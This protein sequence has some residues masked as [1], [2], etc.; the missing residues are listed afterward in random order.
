MGKFNKQ[1]AEH[2]LNTMKL[3]HSFALKMA[4]IICWSVVSTV[5]ILSIFLGKITPIALGISVVIALVLG[6]LS[7]SITRT[8]C[9]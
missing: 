1:E 8:A 9:L 3:S 7:F 4:L 6:V 5:M 2:E